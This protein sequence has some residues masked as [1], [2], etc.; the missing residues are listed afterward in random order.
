[1]IDLLSKIYVDLNELVIRR[2]PH[3]KEILSTRIIKEHTK[4]CEYCFNIKSSNKDKN[5]MLEFK[6]IIKYILFILN[7]F[8]FLNILTPLIPDCSAL[9]APAST[10]RFGQCWTCATGT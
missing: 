7:Y 8:K 5:Y 4:I 10:L 3:D 1:M 6:V 2:V 9:R